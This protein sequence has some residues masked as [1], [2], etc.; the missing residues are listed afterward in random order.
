MHKNLIIIG[1][2]GHAY[3]AI[4]IAISQDFSIMGYVDLVPKEVNPFG[5]KYLGLE[6]EILLDEVYQDV[7]LFVAI[8]DNYIRKNIMEKFGEVRNF[9]ILRHRSATINLLCE[10]S[11]GTMIASNAVINPLAKIGKGAIINTGVIV[12]HECNIQDFVHI[13]PGAVLAGNVAI[14]QCTFV[15]ANSV[16]KQG[17]TIGKNVTIG[18]G[19][20]VLHNIPDGAT[21]MGNP[22]RV[23]RVKNT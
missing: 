17:L 13:A 10:I 9:S 20:V 1:Y 11:E 21:V 22:G 8:G 23:V 16:I 19:T 3:V 18:A 14:G 5:L 7:N 6:E 15:G 2:S 4:D 12:E